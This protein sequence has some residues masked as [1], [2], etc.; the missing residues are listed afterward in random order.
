MCTVCAGSGTVGGWL[1]L[2]VSLTPTTYP[3]THAAISKP[4]YGPS[5][6]WD[7]CVISDGMRYSPSLVVERGQSGNVIGT[8]LAPTAAYQAGGSDIRPGFYGTG[9]H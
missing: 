6:N 1:A 7:L 9:R 2:A 3:N 4:K 8:Q 5:L